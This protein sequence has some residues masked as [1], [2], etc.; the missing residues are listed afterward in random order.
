VAFSTDGKSIFAGGSNGSIVA[1]NADSGQFLRALTGHKGSVR[2]LAFSPDG[3][4]LASGSD[5]KT[6][7]IWS[8]N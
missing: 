7:G 5:D 8:A 4:R 1:W 3:G 6:I 2:A